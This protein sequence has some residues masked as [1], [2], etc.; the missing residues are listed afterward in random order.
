VPSLENNEEKSTTSYTN[1]RSRMRIP[2]WLLHGDPSLNASCRHAES[3]VN[4]IETTNGSQSEQSADDDDEQQGFNT[5]S[6]TR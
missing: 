3:Q 2:L 6:Y 5:L 1:R 4:D